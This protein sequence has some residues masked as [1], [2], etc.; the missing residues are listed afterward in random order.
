MTAR[1]DAVIVGSG[2]G[3]GIAAYVLARGGLRV[4]VLEKGPWLTAEDFSDDELKTGERTF[5]DQDPLIEP[6]TFRD[7]PLAGARQFTGQVLPVSRC[8]GGGSVHYGAVCFRFRPEDFRALST[9]GNLPGADIQ[10]WPLTDAELD[11]AHPDSIRSIYGKL[12][13]VLGVA[14]G[15]M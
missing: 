3:G 6:R 14:G 7:S 13:K 15:Q 4:A 12:E 8:V 9:Y 5:Y 10:D 2:A 1:Y 11:A